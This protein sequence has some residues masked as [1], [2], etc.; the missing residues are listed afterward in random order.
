MNKIASAEYLMAADIKPEKGHSFIHL[1]TTGAGEYY[2]ANNN[3][4]WFNKSAHEF[5][6]PEALGRKSRMLDGGLE[7]FHNTFTKYGAVYREHFNSKK[8]A[9]PLGAV[10]AEAYN[11]AMNRG[12][13]IVK[14]AN[15]EWA[16]DLQK[17][18][19]D[20][21]IFFS[22]GCGV[23]FDICSMCGNEAPTRKQYC[24]HLRYNKLG[25]SKE[26]HQVFAINDQPHFHDISRVVVPADRIAFGLRKV[27]GQAM[28]VDAVYESED[29]AA[30]W[31][32]ASMVSKIGSRIEAKKA[33]ILEKLS[34]IEKRI[35]V[36][37]TTPDEDDLSLAFGEPPCPGSATE[38]VEKVDQYPT[39]EVIGELN[40]SK[41]LLPPKTFVR[42][43]MGKS[44]DDVPGLEDLPDALRSIF[45]ELHD[46]GDVEVISDG[47]YD[48]EASG[49]YPSLSLATKNLASE[50][51]LEDEPIRRKVVRI[52]IT[53][54]PEY[55]KQASLVKKEVSAETRYLAKEY[56]KY[57]LSF[58]AGANDDK[59]THRVAIH[60]QVVI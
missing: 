44:G 31:I 24:Q 37:G 1:I 15:D 43:V 18:A 17:L 60:N 56:A 36:E 26:G 45:S 30:I 41:A 9:K 6:F 32:P 14:L 58:L 16:D 5:T 4:D 2:G 39:D 28:S 8:G 20:E 29:P 59:Y 52:A 3:A 53:G 11:P 50:L 46:S 22:M 54:K 42:I 38:D 57:Q 49:R 12:E 25:I 51:S 13:L 27:A 7:K 10:V 48:K 35:I 23:P 33:A 47:S 55:L 34:N 40:N 21:P 19:R